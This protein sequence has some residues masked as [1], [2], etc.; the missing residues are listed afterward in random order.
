MVVTV[1]CPVLL[2]SANALQSVTKKGIDVD[3]AGLRNLFY[4]CAAAKMRPSEQATVSEKE[5]VY[6]S[7]HDR[8]ERRSRS[9]AEVE[10]VYSLDL[11]SLCVV[12]EKIELYRSR[13]HHGRT[14]PDHDPLMC[15]H[16]V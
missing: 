8:W 7:G 15:A 1:F 2:V 5:L 9:R 3:E 13:D 6:C 14:S 4:V 10:D 11:V 12:E 16:V